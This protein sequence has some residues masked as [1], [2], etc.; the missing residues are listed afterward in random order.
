MIR[1]EYI[2][3]AYAKGLPAS[4]VIFKHALRNTFIIMITIF[5]GILPG[6][7]GGSIMIEYIFD[8]PGMGTLS[9]SALNSR[10]LPLMM[11]LF[12]FTASLTLTSILIADVLYV[13]ADPHITFR[14]RI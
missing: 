7:M 13:L 9:M 8:I 2:R 3:A 1:Q 11:G 12:S 5:A 10:N 4:T 14:S 6:L